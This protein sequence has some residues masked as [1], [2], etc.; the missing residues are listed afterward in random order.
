MYKHTLKVYGQYLAEDQALPQNTSAD[1]NGA[2]L[3]LAGTMGGVEVVAAV[4]SAVT[5]ADAKTLSIKLQDS[6]DNETFA[7]LATI[8]TV[9]ADG[10]TSIVAGTVLGRFVLPTDC[11]DYVKAVLTTDDAAAAGAVSVYPTYL[12]R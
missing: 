11:E 9:T 2:V 10:A 6:A 4:A 12:P 1:G 5:L 7:D 3:N 8:Y